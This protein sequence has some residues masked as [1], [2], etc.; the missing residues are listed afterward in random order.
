MHSN[1]NH[2]KLLYMKTFIYLSMFISVIGCISSCKQED[3]PQV[4]NGIVYDVTMSNITLI[5]SKGDT[6]N[7]STMDDNTNKVGGVL[8]DDSVE[9]TCVKEEIEGREILQA[10]EVTIIKK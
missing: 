5:T 1:N 7:I 4:F 3:Q 2:E 9:V 6:V 10:I 8:L